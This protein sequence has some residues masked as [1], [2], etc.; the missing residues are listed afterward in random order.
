MRRS[1]PPM[2]LGE[3]FSSSASKATRA[4]EG[5]DV[6]EEAPIAEILLCSVAVLH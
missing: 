6:C 5:A 4:I 3:P 1:G 2:T